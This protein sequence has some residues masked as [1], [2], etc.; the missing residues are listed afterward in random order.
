MDSRLIFLRRLRG[1]MEGRRP[2]SKQTDRNVCRVHRDGGIG[3]SARG[4][5]G[6]NSS[7]SFAK[8]LEGRP[9]KASKR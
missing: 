5:Q 4:I 9:R 7:D 3:K 6:A 1:A 8:L 2:D